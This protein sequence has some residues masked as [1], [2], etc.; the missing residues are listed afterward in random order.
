M[1]KLALSLLAVLIAGNS[2]AQKTNLDL[3]TE[4][5]QKRFRTESSTLAASLPAGMKP[6][7]G[8]TNEKPLTETPAGR[9]VDNMYVTSNAYGLGIGQ[10]YQQNVDGALGAVVEGSDGFVYIQQPLSQAYVLALGKPWMKAQRLA[11]DTILMQTPQLYTID[12]GDPYYLYRMKP[13]GTKFVKD[14]ENTTVKFVWRNDTLKQI[15]DCL[16]GLGDADGKWFYIGDYNICY[17]VNNDRPVQIPADDDIDY[18]KMT[19][20]ANPNDLSKRKTKWLSGIGDESSYPPVLYVTNINNEIPKAGIKAEF[21]IGSGGAPAIII[22]TD[23]Y[24]GVDELYNCHA[25]ILAAEARVDEQAGKK[26]F[27]FTEKNQIE[28][29]PHT[30]GD[31]LDSISADFPVA[32]VSNV[33]KNVFY[34][35]DDFIAPTILEFDDDPA[36]PATP[37]MELKDFRADKNGK[38]QRVKITIPPTNDSGDPLNELLLYYR[39]YIDDQPYTFSPETYW[40]IANA[41][42]QEVPYLYQDIRGANISLN[43][44]TRTVYIYGHPNYSKLGVRSVY[45]GGDG[46]SYSQMVSIDVAEKLGIDRTASSSPVVSTRYYDPSGREIARPIRGLTIIREQHADGTINIRKISTE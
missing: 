13:D 19:H 29:I 41:D 27:N 24:L 11:G 15:D 9:L 5:I 45:K 3:K 23:Q 4:R 32:L 14:T 22:K 44:K 16:L 1:K 26:Y 39:L 7:K 40:N 36:V 35:I 17:T 46:T 28:L 21:G 33:G 37:V 6:A 2:M 34:T 42:T 43:G 20:L 30:T 25:Y 18:F 8:T 10:A 31:D 12:A 38:W